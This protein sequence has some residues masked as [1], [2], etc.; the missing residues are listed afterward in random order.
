[1]KLQ[2]NIALLVIGLLLAAGLYTFFKYRKEPT[3]AWLEQV[4]QI[5]ADQKSG[6]Y[7][8]NGQ[9]SNPTSIGMGKN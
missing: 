5:T 8:V 2:Y 6:Q 1:M 9:K 4:K 7:S 3:S